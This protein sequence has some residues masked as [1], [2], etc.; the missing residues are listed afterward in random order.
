MLAGAL[1]RWPVGAVLAG[2]AAW[3][4][5]RLLGPDRITAA[6]VARLEAIAGWS[7]MLRDTLAAATGLEQAI[8][9]TAPIAPA[10]IRA[11]LTAAAEQLRDGRRLAAVLRDLAEELAD[12]TADLVLAALLLAA[13]Q[14]ARHLTELLG[15]LAAAAREHAALRLRIA[16]GRAQARTA[17]RIT[18]A[19]ALV[20]AA[21][22][23]L[24]D[25]R[26][27]AAFDTAAG[28]LVLLIVGGLFV[29]GFAWLARVARLDE[30]ARVLTAGAAASP[31]ATAGPVLT[32][33]R[34]A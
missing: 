2:L 1:T 21:G 18:V 16:A 4:L 30:P 24:L 25:R 8:I 15:T 32:A 22:L 29:A 33:G 9:A 10:A 14:R 12:P 23:A 11:E 31:E 34:R 5:P 27:L 20:F 26:Y 7:E 13:E 6:R 3:S 17:V 28:Q 19:T